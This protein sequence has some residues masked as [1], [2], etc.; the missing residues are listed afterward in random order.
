MICFERLPGLNDLTDKMLVLVGWCG[1]DKKE[2]M[3][4]VQRNTFQKKGG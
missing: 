4:M 2:P 3:A 1:E